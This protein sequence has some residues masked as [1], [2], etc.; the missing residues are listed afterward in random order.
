MQL[1][2]GVRN[3][4]TFKNEE[5]FFLCLGYLSNLDRTAHVN[6]E[7]YEN[8]YGA[9]Y[10]IWLKNINQIPYTLKLAISDGGNYEARLNCNEYIKH[11]ISNY[12]FPNTNERLIPD[13]YKKYYFEGK[14]L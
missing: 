5:D 7:E 11:I 3:V 12:G 8:K 9:E 1:R 13:K 2:F 10:R 4:I 14:E 6:I